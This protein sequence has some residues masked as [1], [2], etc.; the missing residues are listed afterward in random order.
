MLSSIFQA[1]SIHRVLPVPPP[2]SRVSRTWSAKRSVVSH[3][4]GYSLK[5]LRTNR[6]PLSTKRPE[7]RSQPI[8]STVSHS[9]ARPACSA[10]SLR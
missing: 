3:S 4:Q 5:M 1:G 9:V 7:S 10:V 6:R 2:L 8:S